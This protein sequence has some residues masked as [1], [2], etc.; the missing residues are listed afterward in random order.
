MEVLSRLSVRMEPKQVEAAFDLSLECYRSRQLLEELTLRRAAAALLRRSWEALPKGRRRDR[1]LDVLGTPILGLEDFADIGT[2][3][4]D[5]PGEVVQSDDIARVRTPGS[6][7]LWRTVTSLLVRGLGAGAEAR[8]IA[9][10]RLLPLVE[11]GVLTGEEQEVIGR[12]L[13]SE[14]PARD[15]GLPALPSGLYDF[16]L[17]LLPEPSNGLAESRFRQKWLSSRGA[18]PENSAS[19][20]EVLDQVGRAISELRVRGRSLRLSHEEQEALVAAV[21]QWAEA[22]VPDPQPEFLF[23]FTSRR[24]TG[25]LT[26]LVAVVSEVPVPAEVGSAV[27]RRAQAMASAGIGGFEL[28]SPLASVLPARVDEISTW[29]RAGVVSGDPHLARSAMRG[30]QLWLE[31]SLNDETLAPR[32]PQDLI[33]EVGLVIASRRGVALPQALQSAAWIFDNG[34]AEARTDL[35]QLVLQGLTYLEQELQYERHRAPEGD[36]DV[37]WLRSLCARLAQSMADRGLAQEPAV[38]SWLEL[39]R[40]DPLPEVRRAATSESDQ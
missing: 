7:H 23:P 38:A 29:L 24:G 21:R 40:Q 31:A 34:P 22:P 3:L 30:L 37:P 9:L 39:A 32:L 28:A 13:W 4:F 20:L 18:R 5:D 14:A 33:R 27:Y 8:A 6:E 17:L 2:E 1:I 35:E 19:I 25:A 36:I 10:R 16:A 26:G 12:A 11:S 15:D